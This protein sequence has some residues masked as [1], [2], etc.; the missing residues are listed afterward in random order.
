MLLFSYH[1]GHMYL[2][3]K[4]L[5]R[6][7]AWETSSRRAGKTDKMK[8]KM[9]FFCNEMRLSNR[10]FAEHYHINRWSIYSNGQR[11]NRNTNEIHFIVLSYDHHSKVTLNRIDLKNMRNILMALEQIIF[12]LLLNVKHC[13]SGLYV[14]VSLFFHFVCSIIVQMMKHEYQV[15]IIV[16]TPSGG[17][18]CVR[19]CIYVCVFDELIQCI[20]NRLTQ[21]I[22]IQAGVQRKPRDGYKCVR[23]FSISPISRKQSKMIIYINL[24]RS[25]KR[26]MF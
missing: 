17:S 15:S 25:V 24:L 5:I 21:R 18:V 4:N 8:K 11:T 7:C 20:I 13:C 1:N 6:K 23:A 19:V 10:S 16:Y 9:C 14:S 26:I 22:Y 3:L 12:Q 2:I